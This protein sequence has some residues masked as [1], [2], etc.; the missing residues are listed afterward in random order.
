MASFLSRRRARRTD[1]SASIQPGRGHLTWA[2][3]TFSRTLQ[4]TGS[5]LK[6]QFWLWPIAGVI[7]L[8]VVALSV[9]S[10][11]ESTMRE[12]LESELQTLLNIEVA[13]LETWLS[14]QES[15]VES[16]ANQVEV[17]TLTRELLRVQGDALITESTEPKG[18]PEQLRR[19]FARLVAPAMNAHDY[20]GYIVLS[21]T[22]D[23]LAASESEI[24]GKNELAN[25]REWLSKAIDGQPT[26]SV[27]FPSLAAVA[28]GRGN[29]R[30]GVP[31]MFSAAPFAMTIFK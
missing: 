29:T 21:H 5:L 3:A 12:N 24:I 1:S 10:A 9:H 8:S 14:S 16:L 22:G 17:R 20:V 27:P 7:L 26:V 31:T 13:M 28:D 18:D 6:R 2:S 25:H 30:T 11:I 23:V 15:N 19:A 4:R